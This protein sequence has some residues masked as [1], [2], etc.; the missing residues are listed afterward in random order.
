MHNPTTR[1]FVLVNRSLLGLVFFFFVR[2]GL[3]SPRPTGDSGRLERPETGV[4]PPEIHEL[5][6]EVDW[7]EL[8]LDR[9]A[10]WGCR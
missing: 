7:L 6:V 3:W 2:F 9:E 10:V 4:A 1:R 8:A 5:R